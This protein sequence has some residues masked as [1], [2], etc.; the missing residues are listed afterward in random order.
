MPEPDRLS[1]VQNDQGAAQRFKKKKIQRFFFKEKKIFI[2][3]QRKKDFHFR[4]NQVKYQG[5][6][7][8]TRI[9]DL[10]PSIFTYCHIE[11]YIYWI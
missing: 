3:F 5:Q 11:M 6:K 9:F 2:L 10:K 1:A 7:R 8:Y 4:I